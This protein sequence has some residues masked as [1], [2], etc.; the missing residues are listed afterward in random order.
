M[1]TTIT[2]LD[3]LKDDIF[4]QETQRYLD[5]YESHFGSRLASVY[6]WGSVHRQ[7]AVSVYSDLDL[8]VF[9]QDE[10]TDEDRD[11]YKGAR[12]EIERDEPQMRGFC[13]ARSVEWFRCGLNPDAEPDLQTRTRAIAI[14]LKYDATLVWGTDLLDEVKVSAPDRLS[15]YG[16]F[17][18]VRDLVR[19]AAG[20]EPTNLTDYS[21]PEA[22]LHRLRK[23]ARLAILGGSCLLMSRSAFTSFHGKDVLPALREALPSGSAF[24]E[25]TQEHYITPSPTSECDLDSYQLKLGKWIDWLEEAMASR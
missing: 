12:I 20:L 10:P 24:L 23:L 22:P 4:R 17:S 11:W 3:S 14:R 13:P 18:S 6:V 21:L 8:Q 16:C 2:G 9:I 7:E 19:Y 1:I 25:E 5:A 15:A